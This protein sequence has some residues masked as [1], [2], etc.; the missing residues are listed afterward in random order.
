MQL[1][2]RNQRRWHISPA[3]ARESGDAASL[4]PLLAVLWRRRVSLVVTTAACL[5]CAAAFL[6]LATKTYRATATLH[7]VQHAPRL[8]TES[9]APPGNS[10]GF[11][12]TQ[13]RI[14]LSAPVLTRALRHVDEDVSLAVD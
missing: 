5:L 12:A 9:Y 11:L 6:K 14:V 1:V 10:E 3:A 4:A 2:A 8:L 7:V 13:A